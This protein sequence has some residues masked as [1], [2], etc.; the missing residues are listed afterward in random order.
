MPADQPRVVLI[1]EDVDACSSVL[2]IALTP[3]AGL[4]V[5]NVRTAEA[6]VEVLNAER[7]CAIIAD[8][9]LPR[10]SGFELIETIRGRPELA[11]LPV[12]VVSG[13]TDPRTPQRVMALGANAYFAKP[14]SPFELRNKLEQLLDA[15]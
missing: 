2:E 3:L 4:S 9:H 1:V 15:D 13:D 5:R 7:P 10:M 14:Y 6:A 11:R 8:L 12:V